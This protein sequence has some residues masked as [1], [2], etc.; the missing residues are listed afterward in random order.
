[1][2][3]IPPGSCVG[4][5]NKLLFAVARAFFAT[6]AGMRFLG[7]IE[8]IL[9]LVLR[10]TGLQ[11]K[12]RTSRGCVLDRVCAINRQTARTDGCSYTEFLSCFALTGFKATPLRS[13]SPLLS[14][15]KP[16]GGS[17]VER[18]KRAICETDI[19]RTVWNSRS[20]GNYHHRGLQG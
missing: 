17:E 19:W 2:T 5:I 3:N 6:C 10:K 18:G 13:S 4:I 8:K 14:A 16:R 11:H 15:P 7:I 12:T 1:M 9:D 20:T